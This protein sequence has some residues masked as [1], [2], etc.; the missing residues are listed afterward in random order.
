MSE[1]QLINEI[2]AN[3]DRFSQVYDEHYQRIFNYCFKRTKDFDASKDIVSETFLKA[4]LYIDGFVWKGISL[5]S[6]LYRIATNEINLH[7]RS[8]KYRPRLLNEIGSSQI[9]VLN[10]S[11]LLSEREVAKQEMERH[12]EFIRV[13]KEVAKLP[14]KYQDVI[15]LKYFEKLKIKEISG[16]LNKPE[17]TIKSLLSRGINQLKQRL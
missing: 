12:K 14:V 5:Q 8:K 3:P 6:W 4:F 7:F 10:H 1:E 16:I 17:G 15:T 13:Q 9:V 2:K 11:D